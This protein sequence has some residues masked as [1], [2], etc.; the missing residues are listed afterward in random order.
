MAPNRFQPPA[1]FSYL[2]V[3]AAAGMTKSY[4]IVSRTPIRHR[5]STPKGNG[6]LHRPRWQNFEVSVSPI[7]RGLVPPCVNSRPKPFTP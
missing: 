5:R 6:P 2:A 1:P 7:A 3:P 4:E